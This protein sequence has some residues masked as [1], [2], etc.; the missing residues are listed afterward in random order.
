MKR[1]DDR[2]LQFKS[3]AMWLFDLVLHHILN[4][5]DKT[6]IVEIINL[7]VEKLVKHKGHLNFL[8][9][10]RLAYKSIEDGA[11]V[12]RGAIAD[13]KDCSE[14]SK[15]VEFGGVSDGDNAKTSEFCEGN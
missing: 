13:N 15:S 14:E 4:V 7:V 1:F 3:I 11:T 5:D 12:K 10:A 2:K 8:L 6:K 9:S